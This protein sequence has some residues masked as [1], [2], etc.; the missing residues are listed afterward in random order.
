MLVGSG[1]N[2]NRLSKLA[3]LKKDKPLS[4]AKLREWVE[5]IR[6]L[7]LEERIR[8]L[9]LNPDR[10]DVIV[11]AGDI[12]LQV[13][14]WIDADEIFIPKIGLSDGIVREA[15]KEWKRIQSHPEL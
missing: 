5:Y 6:S 8:D 3:Q 14:K 1:G 4:V 10:A 7:S 9:D 12:F 2:I 15:Y 13:M 11:P